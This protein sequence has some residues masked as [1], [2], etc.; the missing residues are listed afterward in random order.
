MMFRT[1]F[2]HD[3]AITAP[4]GDRIKKVYLTTQDASGIHRKL[5]EE[6][7]T[8]CVI[9]SFADTVD[10]HQILS[11]YKQTQDP[12]LLFRRAAVY[13]D[14]AGLPTNLSQARLAMDAAQKAYNQLDPDV[15]GAISFSDLLSNP[16]R[17][18]D[19]VVKLANKRPAAANPVAA[20]NSTGGDANA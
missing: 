9:Q 7:D 19:I 8:Y 2:D 20:V 16:S 4:V 17:L 5:I 13:T 11:K 1:A 15:R 12:S 18:G 3:H 6:V 14:V 10:V